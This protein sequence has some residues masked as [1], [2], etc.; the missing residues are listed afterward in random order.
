VSK[1]KTGDRVVITYEDHPYYDEPG[2]VVGSSC[3][4]VDLHLDCRRYVSVYASQVKLIRVFKAG[5]R[6]YS[7]GFGWGRV[8]D[9]VPCGYDVHVRMYSGE[10]RQF[11]PDE[12]YRINESVVFAGE[13]E[14]KKMNQVK[15]DDVV[16]ATAGR[17]RSAAGKCP[18]ANQVLREVYP[19]V[20]KVESP[21][22]LVGDIVE[23]KDEEREINGA[24]GIVVKLD[25]FIDVQPINQGKYPTLT[26]FDGNW[27]FQAYRLK[28]ILRPNLNCTPKS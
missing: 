26:L 17:I 8:I 11:H 16:T 24:M 27:R 25:E 19:E 15:D 6:V 7:E 4:M 20:F 21:A 5:D 12:V 13:Y 14:E 28:L 22:L 3:G 1:F 10:T 18:Q 2:V 23:F 9:N